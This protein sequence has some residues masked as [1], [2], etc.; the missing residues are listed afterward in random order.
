[1]KEELDSEHSGG[2]TLVELAIVMI[3]I[4]LLIGGILKGQELVENS[5]NVDRGNKYETGDI[6]QFFH[7][8]EKMAIINYDCWSK[9]CYYSIRN[10]AGEEINNIAERELKRAD[11]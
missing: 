1:M 9:G 8:D 2:F 4:G 6:V 5:R 11:Y 3:I 10:Q 7:T